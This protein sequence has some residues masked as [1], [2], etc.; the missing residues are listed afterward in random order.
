VACVTGESSSRFSTAS[1]TVLQLATS[2]AFLQDSKL[3]AVR[4]SST[5]FWAVH[6][7]VRSQRFAGKVSESRVGTVTVEGSPITWRA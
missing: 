2:S 5:V 3:V 4:Q 7:P 6:H 1:G